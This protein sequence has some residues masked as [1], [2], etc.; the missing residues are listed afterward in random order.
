M[1][2]SQWVRMVEAS[3]CEHGDLE[4]LIREGDGRVQ[5]TDPKIVKTPGAGSCWMMT[6]SGHDFKDPVKRS[7][8][9][10]AV[11]LV[12]RKTWG[13][14]EW[15]RGRWGKDSLGADLWEYRE[16]EIVVGDRIFLPGEEA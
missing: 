5:I 14:A 11:R 3:I 6:V 15:L 13:V 8:G 4:L 7:D 10:Y 9:H 1:K 12:D 2:A 16:D